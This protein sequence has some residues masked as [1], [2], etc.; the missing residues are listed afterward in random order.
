MFEIREVN[1]DNEKIHNCTPCNITS[2]SIEIESMYEI[3]TPETDLY[4]CESCF[5][6]L[7]IKLEKTLQ[8]VT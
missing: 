6:K 1:T 4:F 5:V 2:T 3:V 7:F 8:S